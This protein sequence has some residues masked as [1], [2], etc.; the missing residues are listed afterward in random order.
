[1]FITSTS[2]AAI[3]VIYILIGILLGTVGPVGKDISKEVE[4]ARGTPLT[5]AFYEREPPS[6]T[7]LILFRVIVTLGFILLWP[8]FIYGIF[9]ERRREIEAVEDQCS[10]RAYRIGQTKDVHIYYPMAIN[11]SDPDTSFDIKLN[12]LMTRKRQLSQQLLAPPTITIQDYE[13]LLSQV[14]G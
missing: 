6:E 7:K 2:L 8:F 13:S 12:E 3:G 4:R 9:K 10:D 14:K 5:N 1:M 11:P